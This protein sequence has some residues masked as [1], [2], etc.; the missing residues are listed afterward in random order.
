M[1]KSD[2]EL[3]IKSAHQL[4]KTNLNHK[5]FLYLL[6]EEYADENFK[7]WFVE[8]LENDEHNERNT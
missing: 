4:G 7:K 1:N 5:M 8:Q 6:L 2:V 3:I